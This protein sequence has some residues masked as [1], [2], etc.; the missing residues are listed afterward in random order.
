[1]SVVTEE[2]LSKR[3]ARTTPEALGE[4]EGVFLQKTNHGGGAPIIRGLYGQQ[5]LLLLDG[6]RL[7]NSTVRAGPNQFLNTVDPFLLEQLEVVRGPGSVLYGSD[8]IGGVVNAQTFWPRFSTEP[9]PIGLLRGQGGTADYS[10]QGHLRAGVSLA[11]TAVVGALSLRDFNDLRGGER[12]GLQRY[13]GYEEGDAALKL[14]HRFKPGTQLYLQYQAARQSN[15][16]RLDRSVPGDFRRFSEQYRDFLHARLEKTS[17]GTLQH[18]TVEA[19]V[20]RQGDQTDRFRVSRDQLERDEVNIWTVGARVEAKTARAE[21]LPGSP[22]LLFGAEFFHDRVT[23]T[24]ER[25]PLSGPEDF[26]PRPQDARYPSAPTALATGLF[27]LLASDASQPLSYYA[28]M[29]AQLNVTHLPEDARLNELFSSSPQPPPVFPEVT[30]DALGFAGEIGVRQRVLPG[31]WVLLNLGSGFRA[32]NVDDYLR[33]GAEGPGF[34]IPGRDLR[35][36]QSFTAEV[37]ARVER[38]RLGAQVFYAF[39]T[40]TGLIGNV[41][42]LVDEQPRTP[43]GV[44][45]LARQNREWARIQALEAALS[46]RVLPTLT[47]A[48]HGTWTHSRQRR[49]DLA[50]EGEPTLTE[51]LSR[52]PPLNGLVRA[53]WEPRDFLFFEGT[54]R[55]ALPQE[56]FSAAD[57]LDV[58]TC[59][60][61][62][63]CARTPGFAALNLRAGARFAQRFSA[64]LTVQNL[65]DATY[66]TH[67]SGVDEPGRS[68][69]L[70]LEVSL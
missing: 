38:E 2:D 30:Q 17:G 32:P 33:M 58:R 61:I 62:P 50:A 57:L 18:L 49:K 23:S 64:A 55:W 54:L 4:T 27:G 66:R 40:I 37:G 13:T 5:V 59:A 45:Y 12:V 8:A 29:R 52:T 7:N 36:E 21:G 10:L 39:T 53:S 56:D 47:L 69:I 26:S 1:M 51:P 19:S 42:T 68:A 25:S 63:D 35:S 65:F 22:V 44:P 67:G 43:E 6:V 28:G 11:R 14:R 20:H 48:T 70:S 16:P 31:A 9:Q 41:P 15:A 3:P 60:E 46:Y 24:F 34:L